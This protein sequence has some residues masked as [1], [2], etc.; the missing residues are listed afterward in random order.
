MSP[1]QL[2]ATIVLLPVSVILRVP[3]SPLAV[4]IASL[5]GANSAAGRRWEH[6]F[7]H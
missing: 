4:S 3:W 5:A 1:P 6:V 7:R 2:L